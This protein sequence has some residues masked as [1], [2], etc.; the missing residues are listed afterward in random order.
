MAQYVCKWVSLS[1]IFFLMQY[2]SVFF[3][4]SALAA[5]L[6]IVQ[7]LSPKNHSASRYIR[8]LHLTLEPASK[9]EQITPDMAKK[10][11][12]FAQDNGFNTLIILLANNV[13]LKSMPS[14]AHSMSWTANEFVEVVGFARS[15]GLEVIPEVK[16]LNKQRMFFAKNYPNLMYNKF[17]YDPRNDEVYKTV[18]AVLD[19]VIGLIHPGAVHIGHDEVEGFSPWSWNKRLNPNPLGE[20]E[21]MLPGD[22]FLKDVLKI[23]GYLS[24]RG[25]E[26]WMWGDMLVSTEEFPTMGKGSLFGNVIGYGKLLRSQLPKDIVICDWHYADE[27]K[28]FPTLEAFE[29]EGFR[30][31]GATWDKSE[32][33]RNFSSYARTHGATGMIATLW[34]YPRQSKWDVVERI[35]RESGEA[36]SKDFPDAK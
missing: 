2:L 3:S 27:Q 15:H 11:V 13:V 24:Q 4:V 9:T 31:L 36:F 20:S 32:T 26:T 10:I 29:Q 30:V 33:T 35:I 28:D 18:F 34:Q 25:V 19:E 16:L 5:E 17:T 23:H 14:S 7:K 12:V 1:T 22:L 8:A 6:S 21:R